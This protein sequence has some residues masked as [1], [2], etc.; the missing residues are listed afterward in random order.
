MGQGRRL[1]AFGLGIGLCAAFGASRLL[2]P[3]LYG[4]GAN[5]PA[6]MTAV[7]LALATIAPFGG[8]SARP[9]GDESGPVSGIAIRVSSGSACNRTW[10]VPNLFVSER[11]NW[12]NSHRAPGW[13]VGG[14]QGD[15]EKQD[16]DANER[17]AIDDVDPIEYAA[18]QV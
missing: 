16:R 4:I 1:T 14:D 13:Q 17:D 7:A 18:Q 5:D 3:L 2:A 11:D 6:T 9:K 12:I 15:G 10:P 8:L